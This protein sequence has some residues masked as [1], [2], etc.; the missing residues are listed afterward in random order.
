MTATLDLPA[1]RR[2]TDVLRD[3]AARC[4]N[5][6][7]LECGNLE[8]KISHFVGLC[9]QLREM[10]NHWARLVF[11]GRIESE[12]EVEQLLH[13][14]VVSLLDQVRG[15]AERGEEFDGPCYYLEGL[16]HLQRWVQDLDYLANHWRTPK[17]AASPGPRAPLT[18]TA[19]AEGLKTIKTM[20]PLPAD[21]QPATP[22]QQEF[23]RKQQQT[24]KKR[25]G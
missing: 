9:E 14:A 12:P 16:P 17:L 8:A 25:R 2:F 20:P 7:G 23:L 4:G 1:V 22:E 3:D 6:E 13:G 15:V 5:G 21:W 18:D 10:V 24:A 11:E 19:V